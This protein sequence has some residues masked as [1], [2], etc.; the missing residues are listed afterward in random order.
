MRFA[1]GTGMRGSKAVELA[2]R[3]LEIRDALIGR[4]TSLTAEELAAFSVQI[5]L[6]ELRRAEGRPID[7]TIYQLAIN[8]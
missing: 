8:N 6:A 7:P 4:G 5:A 2:T 1:D 3:S